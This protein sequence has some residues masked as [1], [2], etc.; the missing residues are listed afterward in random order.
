[1]LFSE[2]KVIRKKIEG[3]PVYLMLDFDGTLANIRR[4]PDKAHLSDGAVRTLKAAARTPGIDLSIISGRSLKDIRKRVGIER[5]TYAGNHGLEIQGPGIK[6]S[7][8]GAAEIKRTMS[9][10][11]RELRKESRKIKGTIIE[12]KGLTVS[13]HFRMV[14]SSREG[15]VEEV[16]KRVTTPYVSK[17]EI[18]VTSGKKIWEVRPPVKWDKGRTALFLIEKKRKTTKKILP[19]YLGDDRTDEDAFKAIGK[20]GICVFVGRPGRSAAPYYLRGAAEVRGFIR[21][22]TEMKKGER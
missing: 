4:D 13:V 22:I 14:K 16:L 9:R 6:F 15:D 7:A 19:V 21:R 10:I 2:W 3:G 11:A 1:H 5:I 12:H 20:G 8:T 17:K 18:M